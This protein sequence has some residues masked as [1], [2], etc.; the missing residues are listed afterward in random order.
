MSDRI[1]D[2]RLK[3]HSMAILVAH[4]LNAVQIEQVLGVGRSR[5][6]LMLGDPA[7]NDLVGHY[8]YG[9][10]LNDRSSTVTSPRP[11]GGGQT[12]RGAPP[13]RRRRP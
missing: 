8:R 9:G 7:F 11:M 5:V 12:G 13:A 3:H 4:G 2:L 1:G 10:N 6:E